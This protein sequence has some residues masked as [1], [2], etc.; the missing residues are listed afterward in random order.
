[1]LQ[2]RDTG[3]LTGYNNKICVYATYKRPTLDV[4]KLMSGW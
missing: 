3:W 2:P 1:M 4:G